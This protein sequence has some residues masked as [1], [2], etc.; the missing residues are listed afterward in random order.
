MKPA[1]KTD[2]IAKVARP[3]EVHVCEACARPN[4]QCGTKGAWYCSAC[5]ETVD[6]GYWPGR[7]A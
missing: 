7:A 3:P 1:P 6:P 4:A 5:V 2:K